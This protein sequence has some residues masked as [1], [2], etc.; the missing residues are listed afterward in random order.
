MIHIDR[1]RNDDNERPI[2]PPDRW[3][4]SARS[5]TEVAIREGVDHTAD[6]NI[7]GHND[8]R[9]ALEELFYVK[10]AYCEIKITGGFDWEVEHFRPKGRVAE[11]DTPSGYYWLAYKWENLYPSCT[12]C[13][14][15]RKDKPTWDDP[16][17]GD[18]AGKATQFPLDDEAK[19]AMSHTGDISQ[20]RNLLLDPCKD[21]PE[22]CLNYDVKGGVFAVK[23]NLQGQ[24]TIE[25][26]HLNRRR[27][28][29]LRRIKI[30]KTIEMLR[31]VRDCEPKSS[32]LW[33][34][35]KRMVQSHLLDDSCSHAGAARVVASDPDAFGV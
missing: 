28:K 16:T 12:H 26:C 20:E 25:V 27:L 34:S 31:L 2:K 30:N 6:K 32:D 23:S 9:A 8:V 1:N 22:Q 3:F 33:N 15:N 29:D 13:N 24:T 18:T 19:R 21:N 10:C 14:Q 17:G 7:Y 4:E 11:C 35:M 5:A